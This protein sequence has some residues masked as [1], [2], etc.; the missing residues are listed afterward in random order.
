[1]WCLTV[2]QGLSSL[3]RKGPVWVQGRFLFSPSTT[4]P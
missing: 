2:M 1:M 4:T 3:A